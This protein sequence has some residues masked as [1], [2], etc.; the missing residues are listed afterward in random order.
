MYYLDCFQNG[1]QSVA[2]DLHCLGLLSGH[3]RPS[4]SL[5]TLEYSLQRSRGHTD[6]TIVPMNNINHSFSSFKPTQLGYESSKVEYKLNHPKLKVPPAYNFTLS[7][8]IAITISSKQCVI[9]VNNACRN[10]LI[11]FLYTFLFRR[12]RPII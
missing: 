2:D 12:L 11:F 10:C 9:N 3:L 1:E 8:P 6:S 5:S 4:S 7:K